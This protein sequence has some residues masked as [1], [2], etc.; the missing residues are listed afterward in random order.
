[1]INSLSGDISDYSPATKRPEEFYASMHMILLQ[2]LIRMEK[3]SDG[4]IVYRSSM[5]CPIFESGRSVLYAT[6]DNPDRA[7]TTDELKILITLYHAIE[8]LAGLSPL[9]TVEQENTKSS[10]EVKLSDIKKS[11]LFQDLIDVKNRVYIK[12]K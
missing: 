1:M 7:I 4:E 6:P 5:R 2:N 3:N 11:A 9:S 8:T 12:E 10:A